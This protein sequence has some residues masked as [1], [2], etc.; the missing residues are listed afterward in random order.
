M[1]GN[2]FHFN[3]PTLPEDF[4]RRRSVLEQMVDD[5]HHW[6]GE[7]YGIVGGRRYG[8]SSIL[9]ALEDRLVKRLKQGGIEDIHVVP[10]YV[11]LKAILLNDPTD[12][13]G[14][15]LHRLRIITCGPKK[16]IPLLKGPL[17]ELDLPEYTQKTH[18][19][20][21]LQE[22]EIAI[23][24]IVAAAHSVLGILRVA[25]LIDEIDVALDFPWTNLLFGNLRSLIYDGDMKNFVRLVLAGSGRYMDI[26]AQGSPLSNAITGCFLEPFTE[27]EAHELVN[28]AREIT[29]EVADEIIRQSGGHPFIMQ[30]M[31]HYLVK[32][33]I[34]SS[35]T[36][37]SVH[38][39]VRRFLYDRSY[40][41]D[42]WW[43]GIG[44]DGRRVYC[45]LRQITDWVAITDLIKMANDL[46]LQVDHGLKALCNHGLV[47]HDGTYKKYTISGQMFRDWA[48]TRCQ[49][50]NR[51]PVK[52]DSEVQAQLNT[53]SIMERTAV[54][55]L[56]R[57]TMKLTGQQYQQLTTALLMAFPTPI[58]LAE[59]VQYRIGKNLYTIAIGDDLEEIVFKL[60]RTAEAEGWIA[61]LIIAARE[62]NPGNPALLAFS[63]QFGLAPGTPLQ[64]ELE[65]IIKATNSF[66]DVN[67]WRTKLGQ[68]ETQVCRI[69]IRS[70]LGMIYGTGFLLA[71]DVVIT[72]YHVMEAVIEG[73][74]GRTTNRGTS[75]MPSDVILRFD[76]KRLADGTTL[77]PGTVYHLPAENWLIDKSPMSSVDS[78]PEPKYSLPEPDQLDYALLRVDGTPGNDAVGNKAEPAAPPR[79]WIEV[80]TQPHN[81]HPNTALFIVQHPQGDPLQLALDTDAIIGVNANSTRVSYRTNTLPGSSGSP[82]FNSNWELIA[83]HHSGDPNFDP[84]HKPVY[85]E[86]IPITAILDLLAQRGLRSII[87]E[88][89]L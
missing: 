80:L 85:N 52:V 68:I 37:D 55:T 70:N 81:I 4:I 13:F 16:S 36:V 58:K 1:S 22:L 49:S 31:L 59:M 39:E 75:A 20:A 10:I 33:G 47:I 71:S 89:K 12:V 38:A 43:E 45:I 51:K 83:L 14:Y 69:E 7:S 67:K 41:L 3:R 76:Y 50:L 34:M 74:Q 29:R 88:Q 87:G 17:L 61:H 35:T 24:E 15:V 82:C 56:K 54:S 2:P 11:P 9:L 30:H 72:N 46:N 60:I 48:N 44:E 86:G 57:N 79:K 84:V 32:A 6:D 64:P 42:S 28:R 53:L 27:D 63:Q 19:S 73:E 62:S 21:N 66:L 18:S 23:E 77:N 5:L 40:D 78:V 26:D 8:K 25:L 65:R